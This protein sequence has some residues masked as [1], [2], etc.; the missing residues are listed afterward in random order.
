[1]KIL[2]IGDIMCRSGRESL[3]T[4]LPT[5]Q[6][7]YAPDITIVNGE[8]SAHGKGIT[9]K[10]CEQFYEWGV[11]VITT[12][13]HIWD[14]R[15]IIPYIARDR[16]LLRPVNFPDGTPGN[17]SVMFQTKTGKT[18]KVINV[19]TRIFMDPLDCPFKALEHEI[20]KDM[21]GHTVDAIF[22]DCHGETTSEKMA[23]GHHLSGKITGLIG[24]HTHVPTADAHV[25]AGGTAFMADAGMTGDFDSIIGVRKDIPLTRFTKKMPGE[26]MI[27]ASGEA[28][29]CGALIDVKDNGLAN[30]IHP[31]RMGGILSQALPEN[32]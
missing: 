26:K 10:I 1:M 20:A 11:D 19:M 3:Q 24:T 16:N 21:L 6:T 29:L 2:F 4:H 25:M 15:E 12:G 9:G 7:K 22:V 14:Q 13:N 31:I 28:T 8:N 27:P 23:L 5:L 32:N 18:I 17:G 30:A